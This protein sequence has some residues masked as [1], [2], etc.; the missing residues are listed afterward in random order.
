[1]KVLHNVINKYILVVFLTKRNMLLGAKTVVGY[2]LGYFTY[3]TF[4]GRSFF[5]EDLYVHPD[6]RGQSA[7]SAMWKKMAQ[8]SCSVCPL[9][10]YRLYNDT[11]R[12][13]DKD[14]F[15]GPKEFVNRNT[16]RRY[17]LHSAP[18]SQTKKMAAELLIK[19]QMDILL[20]V[21]WCI[22]FSKTSEH[23]MLHTMT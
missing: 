23:I 9:N 6:H 1:M 19:T 16:L 13:K 14:A 5:M 3:S 8:V 2:A 4:K 11:N 7:G 18:F 22:M 20:C 12:D 17:R 10:I 21:R 15:I